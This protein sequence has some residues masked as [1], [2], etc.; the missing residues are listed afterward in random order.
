MLLAGDEIGRSQQGNNNAYCQDSEL[1]WV[2]WTIGEEAQRLSEF[3]R[4]VIDLRRRHPLFHRRRFF[5]GRAIHGGGVKD[6]VWLRPD[7]GEMTDE[8]WSNAHARSLAV[9]LAGEAL[10]EV[11][12]RGRKLTDS[13]FLVVINAHHEAVDFVLPSFHAQAMWQVILDTDYNDGLELGPRLAPGTKRA[14]SGRSLAVLS[15]I[16]GPA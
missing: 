14:Q 13:N 1:S 9:Y 10:E 12:S 8:E 5:E 16:V 2:D 4:R 3:V 6:I 11:D 7:G 15:E